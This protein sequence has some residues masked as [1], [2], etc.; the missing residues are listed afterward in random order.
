MPSIISISD[1]PHTPFTC[2]FDT[3]TCCAFACTITSSVTA[4]ALMAKVS[5]A[6]G[7]CEQEQ[8]KCEEHTFAG[9]RSAYTQVEH[10]DLPKETWL[11][12]TSSGRQLQNGASQIR[13]TAHIPQTACRHKFGQGKKSHFQ[14]YSTPASAAALTLFVLLRD[15]D[16]AEIATAVTDQPTTFHYVI[17]GLRVSSQVRIPS[18]IQTDLDATPIDVTMHAGPVAEGLEGS[19]HYGDHWHILA[20]EFL[21]RIPGVGRFLIRNGNEVTFETIDGHDE[22]DLVLYLLG[23]CF[24]IVLQQRRHI[25]L[26]ASAVAVGNSAVLFCGQSGAGKSTMAAML[27]QLGYPLLNDDVCNLSVAANG[28]Y[29]VAPDGRMLKLWRPSVD[30]LQLATGEPVRR[31]TEKY[32]QHPGMHAEEKLPVGRVYML[33]T[34][35]HGEPPAL[36]RLSTLDAMTQLRM[37]A[38]RPGLVRAMHLADDYFKASAALQQQAGIYRLRRPKDFDA[39]ESLIAMLQA[40]W[41]DLVDSTEASTST[42]ALRSA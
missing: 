23:T 34:G 41:A 31:D 16:D 26:H 29:A 19:K 40:H 33:E 14:R 38:Y 15:N 35:E 21:L 13:R 18:A 4:P 22:G 37:N 24:A 1:A 27:C 32:Y 25:V 10:C 9:R 39:R 6:V 30:T 36:D 2:A 42:A 8:D 20:D 5:S 17:S 28:T 3:S 7:G 11:S 12:A